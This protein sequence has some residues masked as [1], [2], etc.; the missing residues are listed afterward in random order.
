M[1]L[2]TNNPKD[3]IGAQKPPLWLIPRAALIHEAMAFK[4]G[5]KKYNPYNWREKN[6][7]YTTYLAAIDR[8]L[9]CVL[10]GED[11]AT[12]SGVHHL[13]HIRACAGILLDVIELGKVVDDRP[14]PGCSSQLL[15]R[16]TTTNT[17]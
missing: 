16:L 13:A 9:A 3:I 11:Y 12:D 8:H 4:D 17:G 15:Q 2:L 6:V 10:D 1:Q 5:A 7:S 14:P